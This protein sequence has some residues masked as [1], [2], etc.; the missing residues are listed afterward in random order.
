MNS[1]RNHAIITKMTAWFPV[2][3]TPAH[4]STMVAASTKL[5]V[6]DCVRNVTRRPS[7]VSP[8]PKRMTRKPLTMYTYGSFCMPERVRKMA[9]AAE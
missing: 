7:R 2:V 4:N 5:R 8:M 6:S 3:L 1:S 9:L